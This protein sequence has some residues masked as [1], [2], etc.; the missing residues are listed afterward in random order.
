[1]EWH[2]VED[3]L[4]DQNTRHAG[5]FGVGVIGVDMSEYGKVTPHNYSFDFRIQ[6]FRTLAIGTMDCEW[7]SAKLTHWMPMPELPE[8][9]GYKETLDD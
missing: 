9:H 6:Q 4:P 5:K 8:Y 2:K 7:V 3:K 1:M